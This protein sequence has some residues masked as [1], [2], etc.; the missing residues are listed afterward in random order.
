MN[1]LAV[2]IASLN[3]FANSFDYLKHGNIVWRDEFN[4]DSLNTNNW[5]YD[6][7]P[8][9]VPHQLQT[10]TDSTENV[11]VENGNLVI[12]AVQ[13]FATDSAGFPI[14]TYTSGQI[15]TRY[16]L[17]FKYGRFEARM[18]LTN[19]PGLQPN[20]FLYPTYEVYG[21]WPNSGQIIPMGK[22]T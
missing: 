22:K 14:T 7:G 20:Y 16:K 8:S 11:K 21:P 4:G 3:S 19:T 12:S 5:W 15:N 1:R 17:D 10:Y 9:Q 13:K 2:L 18:K 6:K